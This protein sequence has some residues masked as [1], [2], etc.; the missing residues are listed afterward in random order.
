M[1][2]RTLAN[3]MESAFLTIIA[4]GWAN[5]VVYMPNG[6]TRITAGGLEE[7]VIMLMGLTFSARPSVGPVLAVMV[8]YR[9]QQYGVFR[10]L[11]R[12]AV[13]G[14][15]LV[16]L[17]ATIDTTIYSNTA[18]SHSSSSIVL[19]WLNFFYVNTRAGKGLALLY[20]VQPVYWS[21]T[22]GMATMLGAYAPAMVVTIIHRMTGSPVMEIPTNMIENLYFGAFG[23]IIQSLISAHQEIRFLLPFMMYTSLFIGHHFGW[24]LIHTFHETATNRKSVKDKAN[25]YMTETTNVMNTIIIVLV[26]VGAVANSLGAAYL[27]TAHQSGTEQALHFTAG[28]LKEVHPLLNIQPIDNLSSTTDTAAATYRGGKCDRVRVYLVAPCHAFPGHSFLHLRECGYRSYQRGLPQVHIE[29]IMPDCSPQF[30]TSSDINSVHTVGNI[31]LKNTESE[32]FKSNPRE[33]IHQQ[34]LTGVIPDII[35]TFNTYK[36]IVEDYYVHHNVQSENIDG[37]MRLVATFP[38]SRFRY[39]YDTEEEYTDVLVYSRFRCEA[40][41]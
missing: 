23:I 2:P 1:A 41:L 4:Y 6:S 3:T 16:L 18:A 39:D 32:A 15:V 7:G 35:I 29:M 11:R 40:G 21:C 20:G 14:S 13:F 26:I 9:M 38:H 24:T 22:V 30:A 8:L 28:H 25:T 34:A 12:L 31:T 17:C 36:D 37:A 5:C 33:Y 27:L 19:P 10:L